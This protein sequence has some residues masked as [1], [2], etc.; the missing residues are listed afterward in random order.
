MDLRCDHTFLFSTQNPTSEE[1]EAK[2]WLNFE[3][4]RSSVVRKDETAPRVLRNAFRLSGSEPV[5]GGGE[6]LGPGRQ[7]WTMIGRQSLP[8]V[9]HVETK[10]RAEN[11]L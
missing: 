7:R 11:S 9:A 5:F 10:A 2:S 4:S 8:V 3:N 6:M 1:N